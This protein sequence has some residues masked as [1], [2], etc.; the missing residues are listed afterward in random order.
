MWDNEVENWRIPGAWLIRLIV[1][2]VVV[3]VDDGR[4]IVCKHADTE[5][6]GLSIFAEQQ[7]YLLLQQEILSDEKQNEVRLAEKGK[8]SGEQMPEIVMVGETG[9]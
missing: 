9:C 7:Q 3:V 5:D 6:V 1:V 4:G 2:V 8:E